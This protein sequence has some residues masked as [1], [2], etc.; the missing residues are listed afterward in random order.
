MRRERSC[1][2]GKG[3]HDER[4]REGGPRNRRRNRWHGFWQFTE[5]TEGV[6]MNGAGVSTPVLPRPRRR[7]DGTNAVKA[8]QNVTSSGTPPAS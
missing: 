7:P 1:A 8:N 3:R 4:D 2:G 6:Q 5:Q